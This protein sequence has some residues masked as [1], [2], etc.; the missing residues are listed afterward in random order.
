MRGVI[1][2]AQTILVGTTRSKPGEGCYGDY[3]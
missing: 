1:G 3:E 2:M